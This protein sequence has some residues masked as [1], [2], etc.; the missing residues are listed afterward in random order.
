MSFSIAID[1]MVTDY[2]IRNGRLVL[3][4]GTDSVI[5]RIFTLLNINKGE[6]YLDTSKGVN[7]YGTGE[8]AT[9]GILT[10]QLDNDTISSIIRSTVLSEPDVQSINTFTIARNA[11]DHRKLDIYMEVQISNSQGTTTNEEINVTI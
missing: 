3:S 9:G 1:Q 7:Y 8:G 5:D 4:N 2:R 6:W 11:N 10:D